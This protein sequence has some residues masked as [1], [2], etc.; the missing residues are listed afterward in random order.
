[1]GQKKAKE[2][3]TSE[4]SQSQQRQP[5]LTRNEAQVLSFLTHDFLTVAQ[6]AVRR[7]TSKRAVYKI[8]ESLIEKGYLNRVNVHKG[9][10]V[11][12]PANLS[13]PVASQ[14]IR[15][16]AMQWK[17]GILRSTSWESVQPRIIQDFMGCYVNVQPGLVEIYAKD[18]IY[19]EGAD[20]WAVMMLALQF[21]ERLALRL[22]NDLRISLIKP[23]SQNWELVKAEWAT[24]DSEV[25]KRHV[26]DAT[27]LK[28]FATEDGHL[29]F[30]GDWSKKTPEHETGGKTGKVDSVEVNKHL[31]DWRDFH[32][33]TNSQLFGMLQKVLELQAQT[34]EFQKEQAAG[35]ATIIKLMQPP[36]PPEMPTTGRPDYFG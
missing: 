5:H 17:V 22:E 10:G 32:P 3:R 16:H 19:F 20:E 31:N 9:G 21:F 14:K 8:R 13:A 35:L 18:G 4:A 33:P 6:I 28:V 26:G 29:W 34:S 30:W 15:L 12:N 1:M 25:A 7:R 24:E 23:R 2:K 36:Q 11:V 27:P